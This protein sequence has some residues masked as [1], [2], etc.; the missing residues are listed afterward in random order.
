LVDMTIVAPPATLLLPQTFSTVPFF[1]TDVL[2]D[3]GR[4]Y[5]KYDL[6]CA[7]NR[8]SSPADTRSAE[9]AGTGAESRTALSRNRRLSTRSVGR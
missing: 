2:G 5:M 8:S 1:A 7:W 4:W 9:P 6:G 3:T